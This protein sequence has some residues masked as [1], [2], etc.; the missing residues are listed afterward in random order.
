[1][2]FGLKSKTALVLAGGGGL[3]RAIAIALANEGANVAAQR[4]P[5][6]RNEMEFDAGLFFV[7]YQRDPRTGF[8]KIFEQMSKSDMMHQFLTHT[9]SGLFA[10]PGGVREGEFIGQRLFEKTKGV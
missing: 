5:P 7:C 8:V 1:M 10:C 9:G 2:D 4:W 3:G 6:S